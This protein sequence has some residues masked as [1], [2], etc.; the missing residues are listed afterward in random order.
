MRR[1]LAF[2]AGCATI[3]GCS[4]ERNPQTE[5]DRDQVDR[6]VRAVE[7]RPPPGVPTVAP[8]WERVAHWVGLGPVAH[9]TRIAA[10][11]EQWRIRWRCEGRRPFE[12][13]VFSRGGSIATARERCPGT[14]SVPSI[15]TGRV[16]I[17]VRSRGWTATVE[18]QVVKAATD[19]VPVAV[20]DRTATLLGRGEIYPIERSGTGTASLY[21]LPSGRILLRLQ[22]FETLPTRGLLVWATNAERPRTTRD[23]A[24]S[25]H[26]VIARLRATV[27]DQN[28]VL[29]R[30]LAAAGAR[31]VVIWCR[32]VRI[33]YAGAELTDV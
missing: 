33:A 22:N 17:A 16:R 31:S 3:V 15:A 4:Q 7:Q 13:T 6:A 19:A 20:R 8:R 26:T 29:P 2:L 23:V 10:H 30:A 24:R 5:S 14:G 27:G 18:Q 28:Y 11:A 25:R 21:K 32:I 12:M 1:G 9:T